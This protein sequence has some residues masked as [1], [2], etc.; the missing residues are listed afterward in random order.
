MSLYNPVQISDIPRVKSGAF[1][2]AQNAGT[3]DL[4]TASG[5]VYIEIL[6]AYV[7]VAGAGFTSC[8]IATNHTVPKNIVASTLVASVTLDLSMSLVTTG[9]L[10]PSGKK[11]QGTIVGTGSAGEIDVIVRWAPVT[12]GAVLN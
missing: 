2:V 6:A 7:K 12:T 5:D 3:Y 11:I 9:F 4:L 1:N 8:S 10:L